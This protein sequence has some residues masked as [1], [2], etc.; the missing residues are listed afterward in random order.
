MECVILIGLPGAGKTSF[1][2]RLLARTH[3]HISKDLWPHARD[4]EARRRRL[5]AEAL[6]RGESVVIDNTN[7][8]RVDRAPAIALAHAY[9]A[10]AVAYF[11]DV[12]TR[13]AVARNAR[14]TGRARVPEAAIFAIARRLEPPSPAEGF[15][16]IFRVRPG[17]SLAFDVHE[18]PAGTPDASGS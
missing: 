14:R 8:A 3:R 15:D 5:V 4:R 12:T 10:Q 9:G 6:A 17:P 18:A 13:E 16:R 1:Y 11:F 2:R 7:P